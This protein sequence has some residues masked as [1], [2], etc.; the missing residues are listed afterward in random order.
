MLTVKIQSKKI[1]R[2]AIVTLV[3]LLLPL[4]IM[5]FTD[6]VDWGL[7]DFAV[8]GALL[9]GSGI[10]Y[11]LISGKVN[12]IVYRAAVGLAVLTAFILI[13]VNFA[14]GI[15]GSE[16]NPANLM[17]IGVLH[18]GI[19]AAL[20][21]RFKPHGMARAM[22]L[23]ALAQILAGLIALIAGWGFSLIIDCLFAALW[24]ASAL[25]FRRA[26]ATEE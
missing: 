18:V 16:D 21:A 15:I 5:Q 14:V 19:F 20:A 22:F 23:T 24:I 8:A 1:V 3:I 6:E 11:E 12:N 4:I 10:T 9:I 17:Y 2:I 7:A 25:L 13:W 26:N